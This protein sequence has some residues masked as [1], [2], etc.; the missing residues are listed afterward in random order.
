MEEGVD[1]ALFATIIWI[2]W[3]RRNIIQT[4]TRLFP[5]QQIMQEVW[6]TKI[7][8]LQISYLK[9]SGGNTNNH[10][11][12]RWKLPPW[13]NFKVNFDGVVFQGEKQAG[14]GVIIQDWNGQVVTSMV[15]AF[16]FYPSRSQQWKL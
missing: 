13:P 4:S 11:N 16:P 5:I 3:Y 7:A 12:I 1:L 15:E 8:Y 10:Q 2:V 14:V 9:P 6:S